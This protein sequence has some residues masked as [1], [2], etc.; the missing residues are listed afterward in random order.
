MNVL[1]MFSAPSRKIDYSREVGPLLTQQDFETDIMTLV[2]NFSEDELIRRSRP[3][4][5]QSDLLGNVFYD[6]MPENLRSSFEKAYL[7]QKQLEAKQKQNAE[8][9]R[10]LQ[11]H[12]EA[13]KTG[14][15]SPH[16]DFVAQF[17]SSKVD[18]PPEPPKVE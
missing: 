13:K 3:L 9:I 6:N 4:A 5:Y 1:N 2:M 11:E 10:K 12:Y 15:K 8:V 18:S 16:E 7:E 17:F 14:V